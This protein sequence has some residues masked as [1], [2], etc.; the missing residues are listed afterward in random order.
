MI[1]VLDNLSVGR[2]I[3]L[4][5]VLVSLSLVVLL[6]VSFN[7]FLHLQDRLSGVR[8]QSVPNAI[9]AK[10]MQMQ[11]V[12]VQQWLTDISA[13]RG[14]DGLDD[15]F[16]E[17]EKAYQAFLADLALIRSAY[18]AQQ[19]EEGVR[20]ADT[21]KARMAAWYETGKRMAN[22]YIEGGP[23]SG[24]AVMPEFDA[25]SS[26]MQA[27]L[28]PVIAA[29]VEGA[30]RELI[31]SLDEADGVRIWILLGIVTVIAIAV[32]GGIWLT[33]SVVIRLAR[34]SEAMHRMVETKD[35]SVGLV[36]AGDD[37]IA[38]MARNFKEL[39][40][41]LRTML[42]EMGADV[43]KLDT[44]AGMLASA[45][46]QAASSSEASS[47]SAASMAA[48]AEEM[49]ANL[50][51]MR[52]SAQATLA[53]VRDASRYS[54]E[55]GQVIDSAVSEMQ[56]IARSVLQVSSEIAQ[57]GEQTG[58]ISNIVE[59]IKEVADQTNLLALNAAIEAARAGE[60]GR[61]FAVVADEVRKL[62]ERTSRSTAEIGAMIQAI[63]QSSRSAVG[64]MDEAVALA[65][66]GTGLAESAGKAITSIRRSTGEVETVFGDITLAITEQSTAGQIIASKVE[67]V[68][69]AAEESRAATQQSARAAQAL[70]AM[71]DDIRRLAAGFSA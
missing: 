66:S 61:G 14:L 29:Q 8:D 11:V 28:G 48:A 41:T 7:F 2:K 19:D 1:V 45:V 57:L 17:A 15:G 63:Q 21:L 49:S 65:N 31:G 54:E 56:K 59:V 58:R 6:V 33:R 36:V 51:Q 62:A 13:T 20:M 69:R 44:T 23:A 30:K 38:S 35:L 71:S 68:A 47:E 50:N 12:Q 3:S 22:A 64:T 32:S 9:L 70:E 10:D 24:N 40:A 25:E 67:S 5:T 4:I 46:A 43:V 16:A 60:A 18:A 26:Q 53:V 42:Q 55:G 39:V 34:I 52:D 27:A 37:E